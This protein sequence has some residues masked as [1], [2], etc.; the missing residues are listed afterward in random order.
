MYTLFKHSFKKNHCPCRIPI[1]NII[2]RFKHERTGKDLK[3]ETYTSKQK[4]MHM[5]WKNCTV[6]YT[7]AC[8]N[9][10]T[11]IINPQYHQHHQNHQNNPKFS[12]SL[13][14]VQCI[15]NCVLSWLGH[16]LI[17]SDS[18]QIILV[19]PGIS[20]LYYVGAETKEGNSQLKQFHSYIS[21]FS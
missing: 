2:N 7:G 11:H 16:V 4:Q 12:N 21:K 1:I 3:E 20:C 10:L 18:S 9:A 5:Q 8:S 6:T 19:F 14:E 17:H 15:S 13:V